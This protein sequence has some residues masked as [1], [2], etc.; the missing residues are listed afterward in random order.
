M[1]ESLNR[2]LEIMKYIAIKR[3]ASVSEVAKEFDINKST[4][5]RILSVL[6]RHNLIYKEEGTMKYYSSIGTL[7]LSM[8]TLSKHVILYDIHPLLQS[9]AERLNMTAQLGVRVK[10]HV[11]LLDQVKSHGN[12]YLKEPA[13]PGMDEPW[14]CTAL[15][16]CILAYMIEADYTEIIKDYELKKYTE[17]TIIDKQALLIE[18]Q[19]IREAGYA[20]DAGEY[21][22]RVFCL[23]IPVYDIEENVTFSLGVSGDREYLENE[24]MFLYVLKEMKKKAEQINRK[25]TSK[26]IR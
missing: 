5:S 20:M 23:A 4:A 11:F 1:L 13:F 14:H 24:Q 2:G 10:D 12:R 6:A 18:M 9:M 15:G 16:K 8:R 26:D 19:R 25:Y 3:C 7:L 17:S 21:S 22:P